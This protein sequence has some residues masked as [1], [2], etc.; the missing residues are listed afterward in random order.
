MSDPT[1]ENL[2]ETFAAMGAEQAERLREEREQ[3]AA[4]AAAPVGTWLER[5]E[6]NV[7]HP[8]GKDRMFGFVCAYDPIDF[9]DRTV[10]HA[11]GGLLQCHVLAQRIQQDLGAGVREGLHGEDDAREIHGL[12][13]EIGGIP[14]PIHAVIGWIS[15][16]MTE[17]VYRTWG[18][19]EIARALVRMTVDRAMARLAVD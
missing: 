18:S 9:P 13:R 17:H 10:T 12:L 14:K 3:A 11:F 4:F 16:D 19:G 7:V 8:I 15:R 2:L 1:I 6:A 5:V